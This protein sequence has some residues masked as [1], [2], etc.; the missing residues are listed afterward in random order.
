MDRYGDLEEKIRS[1]GKEIHNLIGQERP[2]LLDSAGWKGRLMEWVMKDETF[3]VQLFRFVDVLPVLKDDATVIRL[4][5]EYFSDLEEGP[6]LIQRGIT[7]M[8]RLG[9]L[10]SIAGGVIR[11]RVES[12]ARHF[13]AGSDPQDALDTLERLNRAGFALA[14]DL[15]GEEVLSDDE[16]EQY[17][18]R[19]LQLLDHLAKPVNKWNED[20]LLD[21]DDRGQIPRLDLSLKVSSFCAHLDPLNWE[22]SI[23]D[24]TRAVTAVIEKARDFGASLTFDMESYYDKDLTLAIF[25]EV[26]ERHDDPA[27]RGIALQAYLRD[28]REDLLNLIEW[29]KRTGKR[30]AVRLVKGAYWDYET[31]INRQRGWPVPVFEHKEETDLNFEELTRLLLENIRYVRPAI[32]T[33]N[34]RSISHAVAAADSLG[35]P[36]RAV[37]FQVIYGMAEP[38]RRALQ[39]ME[40]RVRV[41]TPI[42]ELI[43][44]MA[45]LVRRLLENTSNESFL[46]K[47]FSEDTPLEELIKAPKPPSSVASD[48]VATDL[49]VNEPA[50]DFSRAENRLGMKTAL[51][52]AKG[53]F[54]RTYP[55]LVGDSEVWKDVQI[56]SRDPARPEVVVGKVCS[57]DRDDVDRAVQEA[58]SAWEHWRSVPAETRADYLFRAAAKMRERRFDLAALEIH[59]VG[60]TWPEADADITEAIDFLEYYGREMIKLKDPRSL[61]ALA[62]ENNLYSY[63]PRGVG[64][65]IAPWNFPIAISAGMVS[66][67]IVT[68]NCIIYKPSGLSPV[69]GW[70]LTEVFRSVGLPPGVLQFLPGPG[71]EVGEH[72]V[73]HPGVDFIAF[74]GSRDVGLRIVERAAKVVD[75]QRNIKRVIAEMGGKNAIIVDESADLDEAAKGV[76]ES[77]LGFQGQKCSACSRVIVV[78]AAFEEFASRLKHAMESVKIGP[79]ED[80]SVKMGPVVDGSA[81]KKIE[82]Y[83]EVGG[84]DGSVMLKRTVDEKGYFIGPVMV[85]DAAPDSTVAQEE[86]FGP[87]LVLL[88]AADIDEAI[89][90]ANGTEY[91]LT[92]GIY[93]RSPSN[94]R[95]IAQEFAVGNLYINRKITAALVGRQP[96]GGFGM[97]GVGSKAGGPDYLIQFMHARTVSENTLR[98]GF[99]PKP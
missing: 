58:R 55:I 10:P 69:S 48:A 89:A 60:K 19:Y 95:K 53:S 49:F 77:A 68:G 88:R 22:G 59:E 13:I 20:P 8:S 62:G 91:A 7:R 24:T 92:G 79:P 64:V 18:Q 35:L 66:A 90:L 87:L 25:K 50:T 21:Y 40:Y 61:G 38:I 71:E 43:P 80:P 46:R 47:S 74:T 11:S 9:I 57:A 14:L 5:N 6:T 97:S 99:A 32:A 94:I 29:A 23:R 84:R 70:K 72:L 63:E 82:A 45:Y 28:A 41:Y 17:T 16:A 76:L 26:L 39:K 1:A 34:V 33:H 4:F 86:I 75:G 98:R 65:V 12:L 3:K 2:S 27:F 52:K 31:V 37:E 73:S 44:G 15:L 83:V 85:V 51:E 30:I 96:F 67:G 56:E 54:D 36:K 78:G 42:G 93:S 81:L